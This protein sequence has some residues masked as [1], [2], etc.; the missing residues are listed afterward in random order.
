MIKKI[1]SIKNVSRFADYNAK[2]DIEFRKLTLI[3]AENGRGKTTLCDVFRSLQTGNGDYIAGRTTIPNAGQAELTMR[4]DN[5][6]ADFR[7][8]S[9]TSILPAIVI[10]DSTFVHD[11]IYAGDYVDHEHKKNLYRVIV[12][13][14]GVRLAKTVDELDRACEMRIA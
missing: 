2:G 9:W 14:E 1:I 5:G 12:G 10:F 11:N 6:N 3:Y 13:E 7:G 8:G 4:L